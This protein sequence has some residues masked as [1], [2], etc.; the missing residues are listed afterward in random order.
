M[1]NGEDGAVGRMLRK[2]VGFGIVD[3]WVGGDS[4]SMP[5][6]DADLTNFILL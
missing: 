1:E 3:V 2:V 5:I 6:S 4:K